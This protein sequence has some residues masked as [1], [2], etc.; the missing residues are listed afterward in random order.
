MDNYIFKILKKKLIGKFWYKGLLRPKLIT[1]KF[2]GL[3]KSNPNNKKLQLNLHLTNNSS[4]LWN[5]KKSI[6]IWYCWDFFSLI[7]LIW[8]SHN[9]IVLKKHYY[10][11]QKTLKRNLNEIFLKRVKSKINFLMYWEQ[12]FS[13]LVCNKEL[14]HEYFLNSLQKL[15]VYYLAKLNWQKKI[16]LSLKFYES[17]TNKVLLHEKCYKILSFNKIS[18]DRVFEK[19]S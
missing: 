16:N 8:F 13:C 18:W 1:Q 6:F 10:I 15:Q 11:F 9:S 2:L 4:F 17:L 5:K 14:D 3:G 19:L 7:S 12:Y